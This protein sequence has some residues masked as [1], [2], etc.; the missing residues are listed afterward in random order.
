MKTVAVGSDDNYPIVEY[1]IKYLEDKGFN[2]IRVGA[3]KTKKLYPWPKVGFE[4]GKLVAEGKADWGIV[5]CYTG[6]GVSIAANKIKGIR[7]ALCVDAETARGARRWN[8]AN[9]LAL[10]ARLTTEIL[11]KEIL[12]AWINTREIDPEERENIK[13]LK[14]FEEEKEK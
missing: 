5:I 6:T 11:A 14:K 12:E 10:S 9:I 3:A 4:V 13:M 1:I 8:D 7:A 2:V